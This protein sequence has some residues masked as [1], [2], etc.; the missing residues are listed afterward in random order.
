MRP[1]SFGTLSEPPTGPI[2]LPAGE[3]LRAIVWRRRPRGPV[4][5][6]QGH[7]ADGRGRAGDGRA[8]TTD[9]RERT[10]DAGAAGGCGPAGLAAGG[11]GGDRSRLRAGLGRESRAV[12]RGL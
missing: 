3:T 2:L 1:M 5:A 8:S 6:D 7:E 10:A 9:G 4:Q 12:R 11:G